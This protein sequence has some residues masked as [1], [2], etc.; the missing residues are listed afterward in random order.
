M[1]TF[2]CG[3]L[4]P[5]CDWHTRADSEAEIVSRTIDHLRETHGETIIRPSI[6]EQIKARMSDQENAA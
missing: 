5:G 4:V 1:K 2:H 3:S 6:V